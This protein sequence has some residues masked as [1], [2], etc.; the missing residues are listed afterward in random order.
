MR[1][2]LDAGGRLERITVGAGCDDDP[3]AQLAVDLDGHFDLVAHEQR[4]VGDG[5]GLV[6]HRSRLPHASPQLLG[7]ERCDRGE[8]QEQRAQRLADGTLDRCGLTGAQDVVERVRQLHHARDRRVVLACRVLAA[9]SLDGDRG[10]AAYTE[11][12]L[13]ILVGRRDALRTARLRDPGEML[14]AEPPHARE[15]LVHAGR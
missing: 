4:R 10:R 9:R 8:Q 2:D 14:D 5:E 3:A 13:R 7:E 15:P 12:T 1:G 11:R 6:V